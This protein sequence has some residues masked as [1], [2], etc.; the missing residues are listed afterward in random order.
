MEYISAKTF[1]YLARGCSDKGYKLDKQVHCE[2]DKCNGND[3][4]VATKTKHE[5]NLSKM[6]KHGFQ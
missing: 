6:F 1:Q 3:G 4:I 2:T 5:F